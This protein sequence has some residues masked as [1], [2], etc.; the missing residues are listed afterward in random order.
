MTLV[1]LKGAALAVKGAGLTL[2]AGASTGAIGTKTAPNIH[3][4]PSAQLQGWSSKLAFALMVVW[5]VAVAAQYAIP[6]KRGGRGQ[7]SWGKFL[8][9]GIIC[10]VLLDLQT[11]PALING[12]LDVFWAIASAVGL[13]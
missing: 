2:A 11:V 12:I 6:S 8:A 9:A 7:H 1:A 10:V 3:W 13:A 5:V 4:A